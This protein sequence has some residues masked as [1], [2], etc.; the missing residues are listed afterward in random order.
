MN[1]WII[2]SYGIQIYTFITRIK[3]LLWRI[4][5]GDFLFLIR[6]VALQNFV[7]KCEQK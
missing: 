3:K 4:M 7:F 5:R 6:Q 2:L 1:E